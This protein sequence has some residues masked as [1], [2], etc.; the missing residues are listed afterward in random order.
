LRLFDGAPDLQTLA[1]PL[2]LWLPLSRSGETGI[3]ERNGTARRR[4]S[5][6]VRGRGESPIGQFPI[7]D[8]RLGSARAGGFLT[9]RDTEGTEGNGEEG[10]G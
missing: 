3:S 8:F 5:G 1:R 4:M 6:L 7:S 9:R 2:A 10:T